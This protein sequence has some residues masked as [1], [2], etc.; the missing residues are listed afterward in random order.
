[1][2]PARQLPLPGFL[3]G[4]DGR[5]VNLPVSYLFN[6][7]S[8]VLRSAAVAGLRTLLPAISTTSGQVMVYGYT[9][10]LGTVAYNDVLS[11]ERADS[12]RQWLIS[13]GIDPDR[14][15]AKGMGEATSAIDP[16]ERR[17]EI[18]LK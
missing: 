14:I 1:V 8:A 16:A 3:S 2:Q 10:G 9:D 4:P 5:Y 6:L 7:D 15:H 11:Q 18:V 13:N 17:V 12:V